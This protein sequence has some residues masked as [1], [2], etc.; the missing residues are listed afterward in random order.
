VLR[1]LATKAGLAA[2]EGDRTNARFVKAPMVIG[3]EPADANIAAHRVNFSATLNREAGAGESPCRVPSRRCD[4]IVESRAPTLPITSDPLTYSAYQCKSFVVLVPDKDDCAIVQDI[5]RVATSANLRAADGEWRWI[6]DNKRYDYLRLLG[7]GDSTRLAATL[8]NFFR[9]SASYGLVSGAWEAAND[10]TFLNEMRLDL[11]TWRHLIGADAKLDLLRMPRHGNPF[12]LE[13]GEGMI[14]PDTCRH[15]YHA[16]RIAG[17]LNATEPSPM[18]VEIGGGY[19]GAARQFYR[20]H[21]DGGKWIICDLFETLV[22]QFYWLKRAGIDVTICLEGQLP[23]AKLGFEVFLV[24]AEK[25]AALNIS[26]DVVYNSHSFSEMD[27]QTVIGYFKLIAKWRPRFIFH[28]NS[29]VLLYPNS[30]RHIEVLASDFP[31]DP[32]TYHLVY[33]VASPWTR[34]GGGRYYEFLFERIADAEPV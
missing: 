15:D 31:V 3:E 24:P 33:K 19:G 18:I 14:A 9:N 22:L 16:W 13:L 4:S 12:G 23:D 2:G 17:L 8:A 26:P 10:P 30:E 25:A 1:A 11:D 27:R 20:R 29:D 7:E 21:S 32:A 5:C 6:N 34:G 28:Q